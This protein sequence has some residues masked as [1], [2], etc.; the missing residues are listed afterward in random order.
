MP[1]TLKQI[2][3]SDSPCAGEW[4]RA[5]PAALPELWPVYRPLI[6]RLLDRGD[7]CFDERDILAMLLTERWQLFVS[8]DGGSIGITEVLQFPRKRVLLLRY[9]AGDKDTILAGQ[10]Y[11][12]IVAREFGCT[13]TEIYG[14]N[15]WRGLLPGWTQTRT[16]LRRDVL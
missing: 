6:L 3:P 15:G 7:G 2:E 16:V 14:R 10:D 1:T 5:N 11:L 4:Q 8:P 12:K 13:E 9:A